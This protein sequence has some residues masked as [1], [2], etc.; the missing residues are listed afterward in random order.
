MEIRNLETFLQVAATENFTRAGRIMGYSQSNISAQIQKLEEDVGRKLFDRVARGV[1]LNQFGQ[2]MLPYAEQMV[3]LASQVEN[4]LKSETEMEGILRIGICESLTGIGLEDILLHY[5]QR[6]PKIHVSLFVE[7]TRKLLDMLGDNQIDLAF[8]IDEKIPGTKCR[9]YFEKKEKI[10]AV[11]SSSHPLAAER[12]VSPEQLCGEAF[13]L[14]EEDAPY[15]RHFYEMFEKKNL[16]INPILTLQDPEIAVNL[17]LKG[18]YVSFLPM[19]AIREKIQSGELCP[20]EISGFEEFQSVQI[21]TH[22]GKTVTPVLN[23]FLEET[24]KVYDA[25]M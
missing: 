19:Y 16:Y 14:M 8:V 15:V 10:S 25:I 23:G 24:K 17:L 20:I 1:V 21:I 5:N 22:K 2:E 13:I 11:A 7:A 18:R 6:F 12:E 4:L 9:C 3:A